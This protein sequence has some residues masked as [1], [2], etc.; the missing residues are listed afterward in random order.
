MESLEI[1]F[2]TPNGHRKASK[3]MILKRLNDFDERE[4]DKTYGIWQD[5]AGRLYRNQELK[6]EKVR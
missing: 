1:I 3:D 6:G 5:I 4:P 2:M